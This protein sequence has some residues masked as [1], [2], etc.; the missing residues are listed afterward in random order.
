MRNPIETTVQQSNEAPVIAFQRLQSIISSNAHIFNEG[1][2]CLIKKT[3]TDYTI[4][5][6]ELIK[7]KFLENVYVLDDYREATIVE[8]LCDFLIS[9]LNTYEAP[10]IAFQKFNGVYL[11]K[12][13][14]S[15]GRSTHAYGKTKKRAEANALSNF[16]LKYSCVFH[17]L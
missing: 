16:Q 2:I 1:F 15:K 10:V 13:S 9:E 17:N 6:L 8:E 14:D 3:Y 12:I 11:A 4:K 7:I 5:E